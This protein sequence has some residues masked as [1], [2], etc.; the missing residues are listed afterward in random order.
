MLVTPLPKA[1]SGDEPSDAIGAMLPVTLGEAMGGM[2][3]VTDITPARPGDTIETVQV[4][5]RTV[6]DIT[7]TAPVESDADTI[8][9]IIA[10]TASTTITE[11]GATRLDDQTSDASMEQRK[12]E[13]YF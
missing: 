5:F 7:C 1:L 4:R 2:L 8:A 12:K 10:E 13:G 6:G 3:P 11:R 9:K